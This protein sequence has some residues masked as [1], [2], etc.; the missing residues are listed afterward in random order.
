MNKLLYRKAWRWPLQVESYLRSRARGFTVH[1][2]SG[3]SSLGDI[4]IDS[5]TEKANIKAD[6]L[7]LPLREDIADTV[8]CDP[9]WEMQYHLRGKLVKELRRILKPGGRLIFNAP[10]SPK[11][12]GLIVEEI[13]VPTYQ[14]MHFRNVALLWVCRK[15]KGTLFSLEKAFSLPD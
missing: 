5:N 11:Q 1:V 10:F 12:P 4:R 2:C 6:C 3:E 15:V 13:L 14:L 8:I 9:P 7:E